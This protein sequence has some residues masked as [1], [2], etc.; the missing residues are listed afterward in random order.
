L[1]EALP[2]AADDE[3]V[4]GRCTL[5]AAGDRETADHII[6]GYAITDDKCYSVRYGLYEG[7]KGEVAWDTEALEVSPPG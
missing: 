6:W 4:S 7:A 2:R 1:K 5:N 3:Y